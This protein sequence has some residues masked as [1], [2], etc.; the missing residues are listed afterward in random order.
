MNSAIS[1]IL[2]EWFNPYIKEMLPR[3]LKFRSKTSLHSRIKK[4]G[5][6]AEEKYPGGKILVTTASKNGT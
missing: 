6:S 3:A 2:V 1:L 5:R 4:K